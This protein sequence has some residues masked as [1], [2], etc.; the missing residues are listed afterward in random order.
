MMTGKIKIRI[1]NPT[2]ISSC[3]GRSTLENNPKEVKCRN[4]Q[5]RSCL[6]GRTVQLHKGKIPLR[7]HKTKGSTKKTGSSLRNLAKLVS[8]CYL[9]YVIHSRDIHSRYFCCPFHPCAFACFSN[10]RC[11]AMILFPVCWPFKHRESAYLSVAGI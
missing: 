11:V 7:S 2:I 3:Y 5:I 6:V 9:F 8:L 1:K 10:L 4:N